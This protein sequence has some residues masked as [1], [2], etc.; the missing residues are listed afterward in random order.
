MVIQRPLQNSIARIGPLEVPVD[1]DGDLDGED[2]YR[3]A[4]RDGLVL[5][6]GSR[7]EGEGDEASPD[8]GGRDAGRPED[9]EDE[10]ER[11]PAAVSTIL[12][13]GTGIPTR[14]ISVAICIQVSAAEMKPDVETAGA[15]D[16]DAEHRPERV[17]QRC[18]QHGTGDAR[19]GPGPSPTISIALKTKLDGM[20]VRLTSIGVRVSPHASRTRVPM[21]LQNRRVSASM[22]IWR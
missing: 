11:D 22:M 16:P 17:R 13:P 5:F 21:M 19:P 15:V 8:G 10:H 7:D 2:A 18:P 4:R 9:A 20:T 14:S 1:D 3:G 6:G 12:R